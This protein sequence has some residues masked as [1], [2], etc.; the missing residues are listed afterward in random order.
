MDDNTVTDDNINVTDGASDVP[1]ENSEVEDQLEVVDETDSVAEDVDT[2]EEVSQDEGENEAPENTPEERPP[3]RRETLRIQQLLKKYGPPK[4][5]QVPS[6]RQDALDYQQALDA[7]PEVIQQLEA[8]RQAEGQAQYN[9]GLEQ[10]KTIEW[11]T[12]LKIDAPVIESKYPVLNPQSEEFHPAV[13][14]AVNNWY[15]GMSGYNPETGTV[16]NSSI[17]YAEFVEGFMELVQE[18]AGQKN[19]QTVRNVA[20]QAATTGLRPDGSSAKRLNL[21]KA[22]EEMTNEELYA[23]IGQK[24]PQK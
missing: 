6:K 4:E 10:A 12:S 19:A 18:T 5:T 2:Q 13:A 16:A 3:S 7:D 9:L 17:G 22:P 8:D 11:R 15:L 23:A 21:N 14:D 24:P 1:V 20:K